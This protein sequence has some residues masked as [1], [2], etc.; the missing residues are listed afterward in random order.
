MPYDPNEPQNGQ[1]LDADALRVQLQGL[2]EAITSI[3]KGDPGEPG[4]PGPSGSDGQNGSDGSPGPEGP[5]GP[6]FAQAVVDSVT[7]LDPGQDAAVSVSFDGSNVHFSFDIPR[8]SDGTSG[9]DGAPGE[10]SLQQMIESTS[11]NTNSV[12]TLDAS[13]SNDPPTLAD[14]E[15]LR[16]KLNELI[17]ALRQN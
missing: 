14:M 3:P 9:S 2:F 6:P 13:F 12:S 16:E 7:T 10:V 17:V 15:V 1:P 11:A 8:G 5:Q 4:P